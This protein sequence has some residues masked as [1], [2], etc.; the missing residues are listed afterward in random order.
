[1]GA[2][3]KSES[4]HKSATKFMLVCLKK[5]ITCGKVD[6]F[7]LYSQNWACLELVHYAQFSYPKH[8]C[9]EN[10]IGPEINRNSKV[11]RRLVLG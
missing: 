9:K 6:G 11:V 10:G 5:I 8:K 3:L 4:L 7:H 1:M 2:E